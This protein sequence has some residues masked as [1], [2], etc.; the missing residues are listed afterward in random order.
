[1]PVGA[2]VGACA[3][4]GGTPILEVPVQNSP[5]PQSIIDH[6]NSKDPRVVIRD[7]LGNVYN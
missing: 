7:V 2:A 6:A 3:M 5:V 4:R 1:M